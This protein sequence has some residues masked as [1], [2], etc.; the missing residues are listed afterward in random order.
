M[1]RI[2]VVGAGIAGLTAAY[3]LSR[4]HL[5]HLFERESR[6]GGHT[7]TLLFRSSTGPVPLDTGFLVH[8]ERTYPLLVRLFAELGVRTRNSDMSFSVSCPEMGFEYSSR[9]AR[10]YFAQRGNLFKRS[11]LTLLREIV[12]FNREARTVLATA[13][14]TLTLGDF[15]RAHGFDGHFVDRYLCPMTAAIWSTAPEAIRAF[16]FVTIATFLEN[17]GLLSITGQPPWKVVQGGSGVYIPRMTACLSERVHRSV[18]ITR[19]IRGERQV[20]LQFSDRDPM[21]FDDVVLACHGNQ[22]LPMLAD[23]SA[24]EREVFSQFRT[25]MNDTW[26]HTD[27]SWLPSREAAR[28]SWNYRLSGDGSRPPTVTYHLNRLQSLSSPEQFCVTLN[29]DRPPADQHVIAR[30]AYA[31]PLYDMAA[32]RAQRRWNDVS[33]VRG[34]HYCGAYWFNGFHEDGVRSAVRVAAALGVPW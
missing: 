20:T 6:L 21:Q 24:E 10:G 29:P 17:H 15:L 13:D 19:V 5:V 14:D 22:V 27:A 9:G 12:R 1:K 8:N 18:H 23:A 34:T 30:M 25:T 2:A 31:H 7:N 26:L 11:H 3:L 33:G 32:I 4:R 16:P 28:A